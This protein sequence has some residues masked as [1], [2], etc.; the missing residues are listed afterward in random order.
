ME[1]NSI[2][3]TLHEDIQTWNEFKQGLAPPDIKRQ[4]L[5]EITGEKNLNINLSWDAAFKN[6]ALTKRQST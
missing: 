6:V 1:G 3:K 4:R 2:G 5:E